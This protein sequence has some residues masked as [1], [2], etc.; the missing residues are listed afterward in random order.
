M[1]RRSRP[2]KDLKQDL[3]RN[4]AFRRAYEELE[5]EFQAAHAVI[6]LRAARGLTQEALAARAHLQ[7][8]VLSRIEGAKAMPTIPT[9]ERLAAALNAKLEIR[10]VDR[11]NHPLR[12]VPSI[13]LGGAAWAMHERV[14]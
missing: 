6:A 5:P 11:K 8:P 1:P 4:A 9:L 10:F 7:R 12:R 13:R 3:L 2:W 14:R